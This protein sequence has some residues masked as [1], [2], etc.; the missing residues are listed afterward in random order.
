MEALKKS[1]I[2]SRFSERFEQGLTQIKKGLGKKGGVK[3]QEKGLGTN[4]Q[5]QNQISKHS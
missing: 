5:A 4:R 3:K 1:G 2:N